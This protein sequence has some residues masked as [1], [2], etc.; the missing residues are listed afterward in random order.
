MIYAWHDDTL[1]SSTYQPI[2]EDIGS[3]GF[4]RRDHDIYA[5]I[6]QSEW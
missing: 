2:W 4:D 6:L 3:D 1:S 5:H